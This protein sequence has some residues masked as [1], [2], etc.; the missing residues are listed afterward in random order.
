ML[1]A[2]HPVPKVYYLTHLYGNDIFG[3]IAV[4][5]V[6]DVGAL[7]HGKRLDKEAVLHH[8]L[9]SLVGVDT[10]ACGIKVAVYLTALDVD[11]NVGIVAPLL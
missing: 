4:H 10:G 11:G 3:R 8:L 1:H 9:P 2:H 7:H 6:N 5:L